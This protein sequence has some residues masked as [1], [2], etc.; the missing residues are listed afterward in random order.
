MR[1][2]GEKGFY[3]GEGVFGFFEV[4]AKVILFLKRM[5]GCWYLCDSCMV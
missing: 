4:C 5:R 1:E 3:K 2:V